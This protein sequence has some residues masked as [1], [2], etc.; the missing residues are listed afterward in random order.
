MRWLS[1]PQLDALVQRAN[2][3]LLSTT[4]L[5]GFVRAAMGVTLLPALAVPN[6]GTLVTL[7][8]QS[9]RYVRASTSSPRG[10]HPRACG[11]R[12]NRCGESRGRGLGSAHKV[13]QL[14]SSCSQMRPAFTL[15]ELGTH[16]SFE[17]AVGQASRKWPTTLIVGCVACIE[18]EQ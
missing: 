12:V 13:N 14:N 4:S 2:L 10:R 15:R 3:M 16:K 18:P 1:V 6:D 11:N 7:P 8:C 9:K 17:D 5:L